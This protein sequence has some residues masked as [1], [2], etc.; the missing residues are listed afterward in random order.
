VASDE[1]VFFEIPADEPKKLISFYGA[2]FGWHFSGGGDYW[3][4][5][6]AG[7]GGGL[8][9]KVGPT[10]SPINYVRVGSLDEHCAKV[11]GK[12]GRIVHPRQPVA[13]LGWYAIAVDPEG[14][15]FGLWQD[16]PTAGV[17]A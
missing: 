12:G 16:D 15:P 5:E 7:L 4:V 13:G 9:K 10:Q 3:R 6:G 1:V 8:L 11:E 14:N 17:G 2:V